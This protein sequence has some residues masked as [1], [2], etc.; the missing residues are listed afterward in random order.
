MY[1]RESLGF[2]PRIAARFPVFAGAL[3]RGQDQFRRNYG[4][5]L[6]FTRGW[7]TP[8]LSARD[9]LKL[10]QSQVEETLCL[11]GLV[12][13]TDHDNIEAGV[14]LQSMNQY[15][16]MPISSEWTVPFGDSFFHLGIH[17]LPK[18]QA[19]AAADVMKQFTADPKPAH[20]APILEWLNSFPETMVILNHPCWDEK[21]I[22][23]AKH[24]ALLDQFLAGHQVFFHAVELNGLR[25]W[26]ENRQVVA[27]S[28]R[29]GL[30]LISGGDRHAHEPNANVNL[31]NASTFS[32]FVTEVR[33][34]HSTVLFMPQYH[35]PFRLRILHNLCDVLTTQEDHTEGWCL[36]SDRVFF[37]LHDGRL[38]SLTDWFGDEGPIVVRYFVALMQQVK[39]RPMTSVLR[40]ALGQ[41]EEALT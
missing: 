5:E 34:G 16:C 33:E 12:S 20:I 9:A 19:H 31:T 10:E 28:K 21:G 37:E 39:C 14:T 17:N 32:E 38:K 1:S 35:E 24:A 26:S 29:T 27:L 8:P 4:Y 2:V 22:G 40:F 30:P 13:L 15:R 41:R 36:W 6:D 11:K 25:P 23:A 7:W 18:S 3:K